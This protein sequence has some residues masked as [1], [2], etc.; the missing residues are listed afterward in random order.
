MWMLL[1]VTSLLSVSQ[2]FNHRLNQYTKILD[3]TDADGGFRLSSFLDNGPRVE[4]G[5]LE[6]DLRN[7]GTSVEDADFILRLIENESFDEILRARAGLWM[8]DAS[9]GG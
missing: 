2:P 5:N 4:I 6:F 7:G 8:Y 3:A 9:K 1:L